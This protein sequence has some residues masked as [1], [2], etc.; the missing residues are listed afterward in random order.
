MAAGAAALE[1]ILTE[2]ALKRLNAL[3]DYLREAVNAECERR[4]L[5]LRLTGLGSVNCIKGPNSPQ[6]KRLVYL[7]LMK[8]GFWADQRGTCVLNLA[9][10]KEDVDAFV[11]AIV[12]VATSVEAVGGLS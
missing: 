3:G 8:R 12:E 11:E 1:Q 6:A 2:D 5:K 7:S 9:T 10:T 4:G